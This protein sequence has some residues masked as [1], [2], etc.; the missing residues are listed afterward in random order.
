[1]L[2]VFIHT[3]AWSQNPE[4]NNWVFGANAGLTFSTQPPTTVSTASAGAVEG[5]ASISDENGQ[6]LFYSNGE[7]V[8]NKNHQILASNLNGN[9]S[10]QQAALFVRKPGNNNLYYLF[11]TGHSNTSPLAYSIIDRSLANGTGSVIVLNQILL[12]SAAES[13][14]ATMHCNGQDVWIVTH[15]KTN[16]FYAYLLSSNGIS[17]NPVVSSAGANM[18]NFSPSLYRQYTKISPTGK[19]IATASLATDKLELFKFNNVTGQ[20]TSILSLGPY[21]KSI[22]INHYIPACEF[23]PDGTKLYY[24]IGIDTMQ[25]NQL[26][27]CAGNSTAIANSRKVIRRMDSTMQVTSNASQGFQLA[28]DGKIYMNTGILNNSNSFNTTSVIH[29]PNKQGQQ[30]N[31]VLSYLPFP[32]YINNGTGLPN[33]ISNYFRAQSVLHYTVMSVSNANCGLTSFSCDL[34]VGCSLVS[35]SILGVNW[36][37][38]DPFSGTANTSTLMQPQHQYAAN[39]SYMVKLIT[40]YPCYSDTV[41]S[42]VVINGLPNY[43]VSANHSICTGEPLLINV[44]GYSS[45]TVNYTSTTNGT[46]V[47]QPTVSTT[48][49][50]IL[51]NSLGCTSRWTNSVTVKPCLTINETVGRYNLMLFPNPTARF[52]EMSITQSGSYTIVDN[53]GR[54]YQQNKFTAGTAR[55][56]L[57]GLSPGIYF[58]VINLE[59]KTKVVKLIKE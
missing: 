3:F 2:S 28:N 56:D 6:L 42:L 54:I 5:C 47:L 40:H 1:M 58:V 51:T 19:L 10:S 12:D 45:F 23:S 32:N 36:D 17:N 4:T 39:G 29:H 9:F 13:L 31:F 30:V 48:Y 21:P 27:L 25:I 52:A 34:P 16:K 26:D 8:Y 24:G 14:A 59:D 53:L 57:Q 41:K 18:Q 55:L 33:F 15:D 49:S 7:K 37:F 20:V 46:I 43:S 50:V 11:T 35:D 38:G 22:N 44:P